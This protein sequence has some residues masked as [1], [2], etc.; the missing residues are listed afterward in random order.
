[1]ETRSKGVFAIVEW[2]DE[3]HEVFV[4]AKKWQN[5]IEGKAARIRVRG[6]DGDG[7]G[8]WEY[9]NF[10]GG[11]DG[12]LLVEYGSDGGVGWDGKLRDATIVDATDEDS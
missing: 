12:D 6:N 2:G 3:S 10:S 7:G 9:W 1:M 8:Q 11:A 5:I 4:T